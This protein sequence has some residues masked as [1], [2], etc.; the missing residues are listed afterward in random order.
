[1]V[2]FLSVMIAIAPPAVHGKSKVLRTLFG[3]LDGFC[4]RFRQSA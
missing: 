4:R 2:L 1:M 3:R